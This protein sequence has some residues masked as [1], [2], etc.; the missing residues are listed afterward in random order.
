MRRDVPTWSGVRAA[1]AHYVRPGPGSLNAITFRQPVLAGHASRRSIV[2][3]R[4]GGLQFAGVLARF[5][6]TSP[7]KEVMPRRRVF[8]RVWGKACK[9]RQRWRV[10]HSEGAREQLY[11]CHLEP[12]ERVVDDRWRWPLLPAAEDP[13]S[14]VPPISRALTL[15]P[16][17]AKTRCLLAIR[18]RVRSRTAR[19]LRA[20]ARSLRIPRGVV[21]RGLE[22]PQSP[23]RRPGA[24]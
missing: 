8:R 14:R 21:Y 23:R 13:V 17:R 2:H 18:A 15:D 4:R 16:A 19:R 20:T 6:G 1:D 3:R 22:P 10:L 9:T 5:S 7:A 12:T 11:Y 24:E